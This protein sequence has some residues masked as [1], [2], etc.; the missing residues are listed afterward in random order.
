[1]TKLDINIEPKRAFKHQLCMY[2]CFEMKTFFGQLDFRAS[3]R[4]V[5][6][7]IKTQNLHQKRE[8]I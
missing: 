5:G 1:M 8:K 7:R 2:L 6:I 4:L 3:D